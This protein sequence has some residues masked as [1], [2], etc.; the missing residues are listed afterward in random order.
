[1]ESNHVSAR[2]LIPMLS[3]FQPPQVHPTQLCFFL[4]LTLVLCFGYNLYFSDFH[5]GA[6][7]SPHHYLSLLKLFSVG[8]LAI[9][10]FPYAKKLPFSRL[11]IAFFLFNLYCGANFLV[12]TLVYPGTSDTLYFNELLL[13][14]FCFL[15]LQTKPDDPLKKMMGM[16]LPLLLFQIFVGVLLEILGYSLWEDKAFAGGFGN[17]NG[18]GVSLI[19]CLLYVWSLRPQDRWSLPISIVLVQGCYLTQSLLTTVLIFA[20][21]VMIFMLDKD[22]KGLVKKQVVSLILLICTMEA[23][24]IRHLKHKIMATLD[25][26]G[27]I[28]YTIPAGSID[29]RENQMQY[30]AENI[31]SM[32]V[33]P[34]LAA[35]GGNLTSGEADHFSMAVELGRRLLFGHENGKAYTAIDSQYLCYALNFGAVAAL[36]FAALNFCFLRKAM[37]AAPHYRLFLVTALVV[38]NLALLANRLLDYFPMNLFYV[39]IL[40]SILRYQAKNQPE[41]VIK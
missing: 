9:G 36:C 35:G 19:L 33:A 38:L 39:L 25:K 22:F 16:A 4:A 3:R 29:G 7:R 10:L 31:F 12:T 37:R 32:Q 5:D 27:I 28:N 40:A 14:P 8:L 18:F 1:M 20:A 17:P 34:G 24:V 26:I 6:V 15:F 23:G 2:L 11:L 30:V 21:P 41:A 13:V